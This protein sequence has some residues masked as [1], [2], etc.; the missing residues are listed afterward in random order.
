MLR[1]DGASLVNSYQNKFGLFDQSTWQK[2]SEGN[3][4]SHAMSEEIYFSK[5]F[6]LNFF[7]DFLEN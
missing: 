4:S 1:T 5:V 6:F 2:Q 3:Y 7:Q